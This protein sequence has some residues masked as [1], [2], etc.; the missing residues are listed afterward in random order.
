M[1]E[2]TRVYIGKVS[3]PDTGDSV[4]RV[5]FALMAGIAI[6]VLV[7]LL[8]GCSHHERC[9]SHMAY[10]YEYPPAVSPKLLLRSPKETSVDPQAFA[11]RSD[12]P[13]VT[14]EVPLGSVSFYRQTWYNRQSLT[15]C[16]ND[17]S[18]N[19]FQMYRYGTTVNP[20]N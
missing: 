10:D 5:L 11:Y 16:V 8:G 2:K 9:S 20:R 1:F 17:N 12:W 7:T 3:G 14:G 13:S 4:Y 6:M 15:P 19:L 18:Y